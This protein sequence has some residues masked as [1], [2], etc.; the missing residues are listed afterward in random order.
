VKY[1]WIIIFFLL[2]VLAVGQLR[3]SFSD[4]NF[5][6]NPKWIGDTGSFIVNSSK[7]LQLKA[8]G[9][10]VSYLSTPSKVINNTEW[11][12]YVKMSFSPSFF[13]FSR[14]YL[15]SDRP[16]LA[17]SNLNGYFIQLGQAG[18]DDS[19]ELY[20]I[21]KRKA[22][23]LIGGQFARITR[24]TNTLRLKVTHDI[25]GN[26]SIYSDTLGG[27]N[28]SLEGSINDPSSMATNSYFGIYARY[29]KSNATNFYWDDFDIH[30]II[31]DTIRPFITGIIPLNETTLEVNYSEL[32]NPASLSATGNYNIKP[33]IG[34]PYKVVL[35]SGSSVRL[36]FNKPFVSGFLYT[37]FI[38]GVKDITGNPVLPNSNSGFTYFKP[39]APAKY[40]VVINEIMAN[41][42]PPQHLPDAEYIEL[43]NRS[44]KPIQLLKWQLS[45]AVSKTK[46]PFYILPPDSFVILS[47][48]SNSKFFNPYGNILGISGFPSLNNDRDTLTLKD[49]LGKVIDYVTYSSSWYGNDFKKAGGW[50]LEKIDNGNAC[51]NEGNWTASNNKSGG[52]PGKTNSVKAYN[53]DKTIPDILKVVPADST[54]ITVYF[55]KNMDSLSVADVKKYSLNGLHPSKVIP[56]SPGFSK[57]VVV[58]SQALESKTTYEFGAAGI[59]DCS[60]NVMAAYS[61]LTGLP[62]QPDSFDIVINEILYHP[63]P[64]GVDFVELYNRSNKIINLADI[65]I[66]AL[67]D[68]GDIKEPKAL[69]P[70]GYILMPD[71]YVILTS[72]AATLEGQYNVKNPE[73]IIPMSLPTF[74]D[75]EGSVVLLRKDGLRLD[76]LKYSDKWQYPLLSSTQGVSLEKINP[77]LPTQKPDSWHSAASTAGYG[78]PTYKNSEYSDASPKSNK[79]TI[80]PPVFSPDEDGY[81]DVLTIA[82]KT[83]KPGFSA[84]VDVFD[85]AGRYVRKLANNET[86]A[87]EGILHWDG[88]TSSNEKA[89]IGIYIIIVR[90]FNPSGE[91]E[92]FKIP[93][94]LA[95]KL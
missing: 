42:N 29:S 14:V 25:N 61:T 57:A 93:V 60:G 15:V 26:W 22:T 53:P 8:N 28:Y 49:S 5:R 88:L 12:F 66:S 3:D 36:L 2:P 31:K 59:S 71:D 74:P 32:I 54:H 33:N 43:Y 80:D 24:S 78:T 77:H 46:I 58:L 4:G 41:P 65:I 87:A 55:S 83:G 20:K 34:Y 21:S 68:S 72:D 92:A 7:Q 17:D 27:T 13:N 37:L 16:N 63:N 39:Q 69:P 73:K 82:F 90:L 51:Y 76:Q 30:T 35:V 48:I 10:G 19:V 1:P 6:S 38:T 89:P 40:D 81:Q 94:T 47:S 95:G 62:V 91:V 64:G 50:S 67:N 11:N 75:N 56:Y 45:D 85:A 52:T 44:K 84:Q 70:E 18:N 79:V 86:L 9:S 23:L